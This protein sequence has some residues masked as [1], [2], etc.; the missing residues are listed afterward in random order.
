[1]FKMSSVNILNASLQSFLFACFTITAV[2]SIITYTE[3]DKVE[4][5]LFAIGLFV[6]ILLMTTH[7]Y[8][9]CFRL[10]HKLFD[11]SILLSGFMFYLGTGLCLFVQILQGNFKKHNSRI[12]D[13]RLILFPVFIVSAMMFAWLIAFMIFLYVFEK[14]KQLDTSLGGTEVETSS[15]KTN[16]T[17]EFY[18][19]GDKYLIGAYP[20]SLQKETG[21]SKKISEITLTN[22]DDNLMIG[23]DMAD[24]NPKENTI[25]CIIK[26]SFKNT[27]AAL[28]CNNYISKNWMDTGES[29]NNLAEFVKKDLLYGIP[30][31]GP[32]HRSISVGAHF[33]NEGDNRMV[34]QSKS[35]PN[36]N[37]NHIK[38]LLKDCQSREGFGTDTFITRNQKLLSLKNERK[39]ISRF[40]QSL[41]PSVLKRGESLIDQFKRQKSDLKTENKQISSPKNYEFQQSPAVNYTYYANNNTDN[42]SMLE[43]R[44][45]PTQTG[46]RLQPIISGKE[47]WDENDYGDTL[48]GLEKIPVRSSSQNSWSQNFA[49]EGQEMRNISLKEWDLNAEAWL[50][51]RIRAGEPSSLGALTRLATEGLKSLDEESNVVSGSG[52]RV[53]SRAETIGS[54]SDIHSTS[55]DSEVRENQHSFAILNKS[56]SAPSLHTFRQNSIES[57]RSV[58]VENLHEY[59]E[60]DDFMRREGDFC[61]PKEVVDPSS[62]LTPQ[63][64][65][66]PVKRFFKDSPKRFSNIFKGPNNHLKRHT[67]SLDYTYAPKYNTFEKTHMS[68]KSESIGSVSPKRSIKSFIANKSVHKSFP[69]LSSCPGPFPSKFNSRTHNHNPTYTSS[70]AFSSNSSHTFWELDTEPS[71]NKSR[72]SSSKSRVS[73]I[74]SA[75]IGQYDREKWST[76]KA[77]QE[78]DKTLLQVNSNY[79]PACPLDS[80]P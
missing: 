34:M 61:M 32:H 10:Y 66:S 75:V 22:E 52:M 79:S 33:I 27:D 68:S 60:N 24:G 77:L 70:F 74:P 16:Y 47:D 29:L 25:E 37:K 44:N 55:E 50:Q 21:V 58:S 76:L 39:F 49:N 31:C 2:I 12:K 15:L 57:H 38:K 4:L 48:K 45:I 40:D 30:K 20:K 71:S 62:P 41:L 17:E 59:A 65:S 13:W 6:M 73:S 23:V 19:Q 26:N 5:L 54:L 51:N 9:E 67:G 69:S 18:E 72:I 78:L 63:S 11:T 8:N 64:S 53:R 14:T 3:I 42:S 28:D 46:D 1:M 35:V 80:M 56:F 43:T 36:L 7:I